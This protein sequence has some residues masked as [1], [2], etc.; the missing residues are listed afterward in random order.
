MNLNVAETELIRI[1]KKGDIKAFEELFKR[2]NKKLYAFLFHLLN[3]KEDAEE[4]VQETFIKIWEKR[5]DFIEGYSF[6]SF[7]FTIAKNL[8]L[9]KNRKKVNQRIFENH[10]DVLEKISSKKTD[11]YIIF[12]ETLDIVNDVIDGLSPRRKEIFFLRRKEGLSRN[13][14]AEKLGI[15]VITVDNQLTKTNAFLKDQL[16]KYGLLLLILFVN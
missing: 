4:I 16:K 1:F 9:N 8:F 10:I 2:Y 14:I 15:S 11:D 5:D 7:L 13:E 6:S 3:S 12:K